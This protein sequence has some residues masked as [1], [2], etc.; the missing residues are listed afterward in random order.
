MVKSGNPVLVPDIRRKAFSVLSLNER[1]SCGFAINAV[2]HVKAVP[3]W[4]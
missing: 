2:Y 1:V 3:F 4:S